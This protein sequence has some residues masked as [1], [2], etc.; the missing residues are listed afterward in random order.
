MGTLKID[1]S[2]VAIE[3]AC[4]VNKQLAEKSLPAVVLLERDE[5]WYTLKVGN[6]LTGEL[7]EATA[8]YD[9]MPIISN[10]AGMLMLLGHIGTMVGT[11]G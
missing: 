7:K 10:L 11:Y 3:M 4:E 6:E 1:W 5:A 2:E 8:G 9:P